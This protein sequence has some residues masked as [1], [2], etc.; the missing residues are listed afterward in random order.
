[1]GSFQEISRNRHSAL[2]DAHVLKA[3]EVICDGNPVGKNHPPAPAH[4]FPARMPLTVALALV[5][6]LSD[7]GDIILDPL[8]GSGTTLVAAKFLGRI[9]VGFD[10][11]PLAVQLAR[12]ATMTVDL[13]SLQRAQLRVSDIVTFETSDNLAAVKFT[14]RRPRTAGSPGDSDCYGMNQEAPVLNIR[15]PA[16]VLTQVRKEPEF[17][18]GNSGLV[19][20]RRGKRRPT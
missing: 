20:G 5:E 16:S 17:S 6:M 10:L 3:L 14:F 15:F 19:E 4:P 2:T 1:M 18:P 11:D 13:E 8:A 9:G 12:A 7:P